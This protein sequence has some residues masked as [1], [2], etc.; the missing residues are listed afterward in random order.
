MDAAASKWAMARPLC[1]LVAALA[2]AAP[3]GAEA[4]PGDD[5]VQQ[6][7][8]SIQSRY[9]GVRDLHARITQRS[10]SVVLGG[11]SPLESAPAVGEVWFAKPGRMRWSY[12]SPEPSLVVSDGEKM[13]IYDPSAGEAQVL[14]VDEGFLSGAA[15]QFLL[16]EGK[17]LESFEVEARSCEADNAHLDLR[18]RAD[19]SYER[20]ELRVALPSGEIRETT[21]HDLFGNRTQVVFEDVAINTAPEASLFRFEPPEGVRVLSLPEAP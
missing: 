13:W 15:I 19:A 8:A 6:V 7:A 4:P 14:E 5:C 11:S 16:G 12:E 18:P 21:V 1:A 3:A 9:E 17:L 20:I 2:F 10:V